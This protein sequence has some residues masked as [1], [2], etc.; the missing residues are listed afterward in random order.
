[1]KMEKIKIADATTAM[2]VMRYGGNCDAVIC[3]SAIE[4]LSHEKRR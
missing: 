1:M 3:K 2:K 4:P